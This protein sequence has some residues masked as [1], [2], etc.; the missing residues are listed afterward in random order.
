MPVGAVTVSGEGGGHRERPR[1]VGD[2]ERPGAAAGGG[3][4]DDHRSCSRC[5]P[6]RSASGRARSAL[7]PSAATRSPPYQPPLLATAQTPNSPL[8]TAGLAVQ[9]TRHGI[10]L[11]VA[12]GRARGGGDGDGDAAAVTA[13]VPGL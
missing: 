9:V 13:N 2:R 8:A 1:A 4:V 6:A 12:A 5:R 10:A 7:A 11:R 3:P